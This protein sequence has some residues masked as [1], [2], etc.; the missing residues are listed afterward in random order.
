VRE[1]GV[2]EKGVREKGVREKVNVIK[3]SRKKL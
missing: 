2:R 1:K 3:L